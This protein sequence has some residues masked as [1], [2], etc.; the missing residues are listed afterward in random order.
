MSADIFIE[1]SQQL[2]W[3]IWS[4]WSTVLVFLVKAQN[5]YPRVF[6]LWLNVQSS[7]N[8]HRIIESLNH[9][10]VQFLYHAFCTYIYHSK[11]EIIRYHQCQLLASILHTAAMSQLITLCTVSPKVGQSGTIWTR[12]LWDCSSINALE[13][14]KEEGLG[15]RDLLSKALFK[16]QEL[17]K[18][19]AI[20][21]DFEMEKKQ[22]Q[23]LL[24]KRALWNLTGLLPFSVNFSFVTAEIMIGF[25]MASN[26]YK[27]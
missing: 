8:L 25:L 10:K 26:M 17:F 12:A 24:P 6:F 18:H 7:I 19:D 4:V 3:I 20:L 1:K 27:F 5:N 14:I 11:Q 22:N 23:K 21:H 15:R 2:C 13:V 16:K 9:V